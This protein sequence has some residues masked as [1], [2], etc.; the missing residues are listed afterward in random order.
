MTA[1]VI[2]SNGFGLCH[3]A[4]AAEEA[5]RRDRLTHF[6]TGAYPAGGWRRLL[7]WGERV[8]APGMYR[9]L[10]REKD[11]PAARTTALWGAELLHQ[12][13]LPLMRFDATRDLGE[14]VNLWAFEY[15]A[16]RSASIIRRAATGADLFHYRA[17]FGGVAARRAKQLGL[18]LLCDHTIA[19]PALLEDMIENGG[20]FTP[21]TAAHP[22]SWLWRK[23]LAE[24]DFADAVVVNS[25]FVKD[26][27]H[28][29]GYPKAHVHVQ[30]LGIDDD[31]LGMV[32]ARAGDRETQGGPLR[33]LFAGS[34]EK[35]KGADILIKALQG[36]DDLPWALSIAGP[37]SPAVRQLYPAFFSDPRVRLTGRLSRDRLAG[38][39]ADAEIFLFPSLAEGSARVVF[40][41]MSCGCYIITTPNSGSIVE[42]GRH[43][44]LAPPGDGGSLM[45]AIRQAHADR[46][47]VAGVGNANADL[48]RARYRQSDYGSGLAAL[49]DKLAAFGRSESPE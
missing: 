3:L 44:A 17:G 14:R 10:D 48:V 7:K 41:A 20:R 29:M 46:A 36:L 13:R 28:W 15:Y 18:F 2:I 42:N 32:P 38:E 34:L 31:F 24:I 30:Y 40:E 39:M 25:D 22:K 35:R 6:I 23:V 26:G 47:R 8:G 21:A 33:L 19:H 4:I 9:V 43:G 49:Y 37:V 5:A 11:I 1:R 12:G 16:A 27:F 45:A